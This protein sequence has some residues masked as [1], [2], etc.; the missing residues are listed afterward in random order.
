M[1][2]PFYLTQNHNHN[3]YPYRYGVLECTR[4]HFG[5]VTPSHYRVEA[6]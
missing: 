6:L 2:R 1:E 4:E 5:N 3:H